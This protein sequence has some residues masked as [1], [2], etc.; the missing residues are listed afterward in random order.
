MCSLLVCSIAK[1]NNCQLPAT[2][3]N[4]DCR[5]YA[6]IVGHSDTERPTDWLFEANFL[7]ARHLSVTG[8]IADS[9]CE[10]QLNEEGNYS[11]ITRSAH[12]TRDTKMVGLP[13][14]A[15]H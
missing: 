9:A 5:R 10:F 6:M 2:P 8:N 15:P 11:V 12:S 4:Q 1:C 14:F 13:N 3:Q 7:F